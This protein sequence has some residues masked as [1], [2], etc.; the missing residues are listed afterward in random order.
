MKEAQELCFLGA[1]LATHP[2]LFSRLVQKEGGIEKGLQLSPAPLPSW[3][4]VEPHS[5]AA[6]PQTGNTRACVFSFRRSTEK[7]QIYLGPE[8]S[9][10]PD[11]RDKR[12]SRPPFP[13]VSARRW[14][15]RQVRHRRAA[16]S[17]PYYSS[18]QG[19]HPVRAG[20]DGSGLRPVAGG[21]PRRNQ[22]HW[23]FPS[24]NSA[25]TAVKDPNNPCVWWFGPAVKKICPAGSLAAFRLS[26]LTLP[27][28]SDQMPL[29]AI[30]FPFASSSNPSNFPVARS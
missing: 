29:I 28:L 8:T 24:V 19:V 18:S 12:E 2:S 23:S 22:N 30:G 20:N 6:L 10:H 5:F 27:E 9:G 1:A 14:I 21:R 4:S 16:Q 25:W 7:G 17:R 13:H 15:S 26:G 3:Q 11:A